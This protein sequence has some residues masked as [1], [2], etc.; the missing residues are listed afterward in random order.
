MRDRVE[1]ANQSAQVRQHRPAFIEQHAVRHHQHRPELDV[2]PGRTDEFLDVGADG[3]LAARDQQGVDILAQVAE[4]ANGRFGI[5]FLAED[6]RVLLRAVAAIEIAL[7]RG[8]EDRRV[9]RYDRCLEN[10]ATIEIPEVGAEVL[11]H[12]GVVLQQPL[13]EPVPVGSH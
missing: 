1:A 6:F 9:R 11:D 3:A 10:I 13:Y 7:V 2:L 8:V 5:E 4:E 12:E